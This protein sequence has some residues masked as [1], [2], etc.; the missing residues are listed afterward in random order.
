MQWSAICIH[1]S[2][3][4]EDASLLWIVGDSQAWDIKV[5]DLLLKDWTSFLEN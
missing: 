4:N 1:Q 5:L 2:T 3:N